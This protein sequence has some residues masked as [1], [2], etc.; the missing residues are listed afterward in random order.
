VCEET[1]CNVAAS[2]LGYLQLQKNVSAGETVQL[3]MTGEKEAEQ[4]LEALL[5]PTV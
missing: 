4:L 1:F 2:L 3:G 5:P